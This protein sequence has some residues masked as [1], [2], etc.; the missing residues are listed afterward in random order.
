MGMRRRLVKAGAMAVTTL[1]G[2]GAIALNLGI[3]QSGG[4]P[5]GALALPPPADAAVS[6]EGTAGTA[7]QPETQTIYVDIP[8]DA[9]SPAGSRVLRPTTAASS[10]RSAPA[11]ASPPRAVQAKAAQAKP[12]QAKTAQGQTPQPATP[13]NAALRA[14]AP[15]AAPSIAPAPAVAPAAS[16]E[17]VA[18]PPT[19]SGPTNQQG[20]NDPRNTPA[21]ALPPPPGPLLIDAGE[22]ETDE[23]GDERG[24]QEDEENE[25]GEGRPSVT[26]EIDEQGGNEGDE[27][28]G[29]DASTRAWRQAATDGP[30]AE[31]IAQRDREQDSGEDRDDQ[32][33]GAPPPVTPPPVTPPPVTPPPPA[34]ATTVSQR[35]TATAVGSRPIGLDTVVANDGTAAASVS[36]EIDVSGTFLPG[37]LEAKGGGLACSAY[38]ARPVA[39]ATFTCTGSVA[40]KSFAIV[41]VS[42]GSSIMSA[43]AGQTVSATASLNPGAQLATATATYA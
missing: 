5:S 8:D 35:F 7:I 26:E 14:V 33:C 34:S 43:A 10:A 30:L 17:V 9:P 22:C 2:S 39:K 28:D 6:I 31:R 32:S 1:G 16:P 19:S 20:E 21:P 42:S 18:P 11:Q 27:N 41:T 36:L 12:A 4:S 37:Y 24:D 3:A 23:R 15:I 29:D 38:V 40:A 13:A 25:D